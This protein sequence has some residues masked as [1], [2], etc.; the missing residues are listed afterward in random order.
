MADPTLKDVLKAIAEV[1]RQMATKVDLAALDTKV[2]ALDT[3]VDALD[4]KVDALDT[5]RVALDAK[6]A[7]RS[8]PGSTPIAPKPRTASRISTRSYRI[9]RPFTA[10]SR[11][12]SR[13]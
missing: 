2:D 13:P 4:T 5:K 8:T 7:P 3:K 10:R 11:R 6:G 9:T 12:T 1:Q